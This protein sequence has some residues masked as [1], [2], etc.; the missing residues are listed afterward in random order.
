MVSTVFLFTCK[1]VYF[2]S[3]LLPTPID[4]DVGTLAYFHYTQMSIYGFYCSLDIVLEP[5][6]KLVMGNGPSDIIILLKIHTV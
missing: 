6:N 1:R 4:N 3:S 2:L 5:Y